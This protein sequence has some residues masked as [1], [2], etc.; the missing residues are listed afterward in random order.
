MKTDE[1]YT[2]QKQLKSMM[3]D[4]R[5]WVKVLQHSEAQQSL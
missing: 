5:S 3:L 1:E 4:T 2:D